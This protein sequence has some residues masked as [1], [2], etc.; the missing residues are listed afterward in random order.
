MGFPRNIRGYYHL[1]HTVLVPASTVA[2]APLLDV[3]NFGATSGVGFALLRAQA[4]VAQLAVATLTK[5]HAL[6]VARTT[7]ND[8]AGG[9]GARTGLTPVSYVQGAPAS[10]LTCGG[11]DGTST[12]GVG[13]AAA[14]VVA[15]A[16]AA[17][18]FEM[19]A[20]T[21]PAAAVPL[22]SPREWNP[23]SVFTPTFYGGLLPNT[24]AANA[25][26]AEGLV[27][28]LNGAFQVAGTANVTIDLD[29]VEFV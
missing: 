6:E 8:T 19:R 4:T 28:R 26:H 13:V 18:P 1:R 21:L 14:Q 25:S 20:T 23:D 7:A 27:V 29:W 9:A 15:G 10:V 11:W 12:T 16:V 2:N 5:Q 24:G 3:V 17:F 22:V